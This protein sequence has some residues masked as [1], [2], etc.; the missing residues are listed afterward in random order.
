MSELSRKLI[1]NSLF[2]T[3]PPVSVSEPNLATNLSPNTLLLPVSPILD[4]N[5][6]S[7]TT[8]RS[9]GRG[10]VSLLTGLGTI[11]PS[12]T[13]V[14]SPFV[15]SCAA[16]STSRA[17]ISLVTCVTASL[18]VIFVLLRR[19]FIRSLTDI[20]TAAPLSTN[21]LLSPSSLSFSN[22]CWTSDFFWSSRALAF[23]AAVCPPSTCPRWSNVTESINL[24][25][26]GV[27]STEA[28]CPSSLASVSVAPCSE[29]STLPTTAPLVSVVASLVISGACGSV[30]TLS[31]LLVSLTVPTSV[32]PV[33][34]TLPTC[35]VTS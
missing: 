10:L 26:V 23:A 8:E 7:T 27:S 3:T 5:L 25:P 9:A 15:A 13:S 21:C 20:S 24:S 28:G 29:S 1:A 30:G 4:T 19:F 14:S 17:S 35:E 22:F 11:A 2:V 34:I 6:L 31:L 16:I 33:S 32:A 18:A 12:T